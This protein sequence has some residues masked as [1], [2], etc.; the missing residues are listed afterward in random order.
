MDG[1]RSGPL[2]QVLRRLGGSSGDDDLRQAAWVARCV[3]RGAGAPLGPPDVIALADVL[4]TRAA[5]RD[6]V[7]FRRGAPADGVWI[8]RDGRVELSVGSGHRRAVVHVLR[9]GDVDG[10]I[11]LLLGMP[12][13]YTARA[14]SDVTLLFLRAPDFDKLVQQ[15]PAITRRWMSSIA[16]RLAASQQRVLGLVGKSLPEQLA[17]LLLDE[18]ENATEAPKVELTQRTIAAMLGARRPSLNKLLK[19][20][21]EDG[22]VEPGYGVIKIIDPGR[23][24]KL[25]G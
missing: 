25:V 6:T 17:R 20:F 19:Q 8:V 5:P 21:E 11:Q 15:H 18:A 22:L 10:D 12:M 1:P 2:A 7:I 4:I 13:P 24:S 3:G 9:A 23:L 14:L 16:L